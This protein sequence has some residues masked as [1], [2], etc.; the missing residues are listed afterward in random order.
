MSKREFEQRITIL[1]KEAIP[2]LE[3]T[4]SRLKKDYDEVIKTLKDKEG[5]SHHI[6]KRKEDIETTLTTIADIPEEKL[7]EI[8]KIM[9]YITQ[10]KCL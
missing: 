6:E 9:Y 1:K 5:F 2:E 3:E 8:A 4:I 7:N 10:L